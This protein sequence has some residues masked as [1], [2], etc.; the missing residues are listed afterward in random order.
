MALGPPTRRRLQAARAAL[1]QATARLPQRDERY[2]ILV[3]LGDNADIPSAIDQRAILSGVSLL[4]QAFEKAIGY[5][6]RSDI[7]A[8]EINKLF[9]S[10]EGGAGMFATFN[11]KIQ[12][13]RALGILSEYAY[14]DMYTLQSIRNDFAHTRLASSF[15]TK[16]VEDLIGLFHRN[17]DIDTGISGM[18]NT[19]GRRNQIIYVIMTYYFNIDVYMPGIPV[20]HE[21]LTQI[22]Q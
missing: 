18:T 5:H 22:P 10:S 1:R 21:S 8:P 14:E 17:A 11:A 4:E 6:F 3:G 12:I 13:S 2:E 9:V 20:T 15:Q 19:L 16:E 7:T